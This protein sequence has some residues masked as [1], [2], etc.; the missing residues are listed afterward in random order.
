MKRTLYIFILTL[1]ALTSCSTARYVAKTDMALVR[2][3]ALVTPLAE[4]SYMSSEDEVVEDAALT[5][6]SARL[7]KEAVLHSGIPITDIIDLNE[8]M[9]DDDVAD[10]IA[11]LQSMNPKKSGMTAIPPA[12]D[13]LLEDHGKRYGLVVFSHGFD[14]DARNYRKAV[15]RGTVI[16]LIVTVATLGMFTMYETP[17]RYLLDSTVAIVDSETDEIIYFNHDAREASPTR[18]AHVEAQFEKLIKK[19]RKL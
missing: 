12:L 2:D 1:S 19:F 10:E 11:A 8:E 17:M 15:V 14:R 7:M 16:G 3:I 5:A 18:E 6:E 13:R 4:I 9:F